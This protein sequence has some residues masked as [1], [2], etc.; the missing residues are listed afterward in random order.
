MRL[1]QDIRR[2]SIFLIGCFALATLLAGCSSPPPP[3]PTSARMDD[4]L[5]SSSVTVY[6]PAVVSD[7]I[8]YD[9][10]SMP[11]LADFLRKRTTGSVVVSTEQIRGYNQQFA[12]PRAAWEIMRDSV[13]AHLAVYPLKTDYGAWAVYVFTPGTN[14]ASDVQV[15]LFDNQ[16]NVVRR[17]NVRQFDKQPHSPAECTE[18]V[19]AVIRQREAIAKTP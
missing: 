19:M 11:I 15:M 17:F 9:N 18:L 3:E 8:T 10:A 12:T 7:T 1:S 4:V 13:R 16:G 6:P 14:Q 2:A 5:G